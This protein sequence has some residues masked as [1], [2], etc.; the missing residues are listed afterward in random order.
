MTGAVRLWVLALGLSTARLP[1][2]A[3]VVIGSVLI[4]VEPAETSRWIGFFQDTGMYLS[5]LSFAIAGSLFAVCGY[6]TGMTA[7]TA[8][9]ELS[10]SPRSP[11]AVIA[12]RAAGDL[13]WLQGALAVVHLTAFARTVVASGT[14]S[15]AGWSLSLLGL[16]SAALCYCAGMLTGQVVRHAAGLFVIATVPYALSLLAREVALDRAMTN[17]QHLVGPFIDQSW[18]PSLLPNHAAI[19]LLVAYCVLLAVTLGSVVAGRIVTV[20]GKVRP[21][22][23]VWPL[24]GTAAA[25]LT[26]FMGVG[27][28]DFYTPRTE[29]Y[30]CDERERVCAWERTATAT[31]GVSTW[32]SAYELVDATL[33]P[34]PHPEL[35]FAE[36]GAPPAGTDYVIISPPPGRLTPERIAGLMLPEY[37][38]RMV[39]ASCPTDPTAP[40]TTH[41]LLETLS[42]AVTGDD[43]P[44]EMAEAQRLLETCA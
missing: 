27:A 32:V 43:P 12:V 9:P 16:A 42:R 29:G 18:G 8:S 10:R 1:A 36:A 11:A 23:V 13:T 39:A 14:L 4:F 26:L 7:L 38:T 19:L 30:A 5:V 37:A 22:T 20:S 21:A 44:G 2:V 6:Y 24:A 28:S 40:R 17:A 25:A 34:L 3:V 15:G 33:E 35:R 31:E 41:Q